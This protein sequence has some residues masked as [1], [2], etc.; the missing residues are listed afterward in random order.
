[1][2]KYR[3]PDLSDFWDLSKEFKRVV[4]QVRYK[5]SMNLF[6]ALSGTVLF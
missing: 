3:P 1:M 2:A 5:K 4:L 6:H